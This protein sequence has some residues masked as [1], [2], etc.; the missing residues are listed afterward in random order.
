MPSHLVL[1]AGA[2]AAAS[3][4]DGLLGAT[5]V[6]ALFLHVVGKD[7]MR[8]IANEEV[9]SDLDA[10]GA[11]RLHLFEKARGINDD[12]VGDDRTNL[13]PENAAGEE[14]EFESLA[15]GDDRMAGVGAAIVAND[16][17]VLFRQKVND[18]SLGL[19]AP[20]Q[21]DDTRAGHTLTF[22]Q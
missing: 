3:G 21:P 5:L 17:I 1:I 4:A 7:D 9:A 18:F 20:L 14:R 12:T 11:E 8:M 10:G 19:V 2:D 16:E 22:P 13:R 6:K 15:V